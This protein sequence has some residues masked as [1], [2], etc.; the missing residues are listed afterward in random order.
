MGVGYGSGHEQSSM[1]DHHSTSLAT[2]S[3]S[4]NAMNGINTI[5]AT[6]TIKEEAETS[7]DS[8]TIDVEGHDDDDLDSEPTAK[9]MKTEFNSVEDKAWIQ[10]LRTH[11]VVPLI[12]HPK[13]ISF[14]KP[15]DPIALGKQ[16]SQK[17]RENKFPFF[18]ICTGFFIP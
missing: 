8:L 3:A 7:A 1:E 4:I 12:R 13:S 10:A 11:V 9:L 17:F 18:L 6:P 14:R 5:N 16:K 15:V 2:P